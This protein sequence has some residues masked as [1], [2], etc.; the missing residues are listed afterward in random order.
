MFLILSRH[1]FQ[2]THMFLSLLVFPGVQQNLL[3]LNR[4]F[5]WHIH[6]SGTY[7][8]F[9][10]DSSWHFIWHIFRH[11]VCHFISSIIW[12]QIWYSICHSIWHKFWHIFWHVVWHAIWHVVCHSIWHVWYIWL[13][14]HNVRVQRAHRASPF[15]SGPARRREG[16]LP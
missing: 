7:A 4:H 10:S 15:C 9:L 11:S 12:H 1:I 16:I 2:R 13:W 3:S 5:I 14:Q 8:D 6:W